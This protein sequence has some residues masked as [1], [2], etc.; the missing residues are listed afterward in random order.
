MFCLFS[1]V[2]SDPLVLLSFS[3]NCY[4]LYCPPCAY[5]KNDILFFARRLGRLVFYFELLMLCYVKCAS[6]YANVGGCDSL[7]G[8]APPFTHPAPFDHRSPKY[9]KKNE[10]TSAQV[11]PH[12]TS[13]FS[14]LFFLVAAGDIARRDSGGVDRTHPRGGGIH[15]S[16]PGFHG[17]RSIV[18]RQAQHPSDRRRGSVR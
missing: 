13:M 6:M 11:Y 18:L 7:T 10:I 12:T 4:Y 3:F 14:P 8:S 1:V 2:L 16:A 5:A 17:R 15:C 9:L